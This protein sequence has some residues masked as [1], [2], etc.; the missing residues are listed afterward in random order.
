MLVRVPFRREFRAW[1]AKHPLIAAACISIVWAG[2]ILLVFP[3]GPHPGFARWVALAAGL[4]VAFP[5]CYYVFA[6]QRSR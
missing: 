1:S 4:V 2:Y 3:W 6:R 5:G